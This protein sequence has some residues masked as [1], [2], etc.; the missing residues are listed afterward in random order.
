LQNSTA[1]SDRSTSSWWSSRGPNK[2]T[3]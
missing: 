1:T 3:N 2:I